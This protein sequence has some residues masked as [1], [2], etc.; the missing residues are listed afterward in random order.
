MTGWDARG[1]SRYRREG[2]F[3]ARFFVEG[4]VWDAADMF[5]E[6]VGTLAAQAAVSEN[7]RLGLGNR[8]RVNIAAVKVRERIFLPA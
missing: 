5:P 6:W 4:G 8:G 3:I 2:D 7:P 1:L